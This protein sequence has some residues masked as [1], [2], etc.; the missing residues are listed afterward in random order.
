[1]ALARTKLA[2][3]RGAKI[4]PL[5]SNQQKLPLKIPTSASST[6][7]SGKRKHKATQGVQTDQTQLETVQ[8]GMAQSERTNKTEHDRTSKVDDRRQRSVEE[9]ASDHRRQ[10]SKVEIL[11]NEHKSETM[12]SL[13]SGQQVQYSVKSVPG[14]RSQ[15]SEHE[16]GMI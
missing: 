4:V 10:E 13:H 8:S 11:G 2:E 5:P 6:T 3:M 15:S 14:Q 12:R 16:V 1:M 9:E 7:S